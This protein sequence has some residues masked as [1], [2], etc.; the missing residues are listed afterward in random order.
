MSDDSGPPVN[1]H[2]LTS[3][4]PVEEIPRS[5]LEARRKFEGIYSLA[6]GPEDLKGLASIIAE[7]DAAVCLGRGAGAQTHS[8]FCYQTSV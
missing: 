6:H 5:G 1:L 3:K 4:E 7:S 8:I 2:L